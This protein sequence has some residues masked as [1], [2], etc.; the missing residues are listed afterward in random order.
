MKE[1]SL[2]MIVK[3]EE[4]II[5]RCLDS[6][7][8]LVDEIII[9]DTGSTDRTKEIVSKYTD[10]VFDF[11]WVDDFAKARNFSFSKA[12]KDYILWLDADDIILEEDRKNF[13]KLKNELDGSVDIYQMKYNYTVDENNNPTFV[14]VRVRLVKREKNYQWVSPIHEV[15]IPSGNIKKVDISITHKKEEIKD[16]ERNLKIFQKLEKEG[17]I[18]D[19]RQEYCYA[20]EFYCLR[21]YEEAVSKYEKYI[22]KYEN[23]YKTKRIFLYPAILELSDC[24]K[25]LEKYDKRLE[26]LLKVLKYEIPGSSACCKIGECFMDRK[27]YDTARFWFESAIRNKK[28]VKED[29]DANVDYNEYVP[30]IDLCVCYYW[31]GDLEK[32][33]ECN[34]KA[35]RIKPDSETYLYNKKILK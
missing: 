4:D 1:I 21:R 15:I 34:E 25:I 23:D 9:V 18:L 33:R 31:L 3:N 19:D 32:A 27:E 2:C 16:S 26:I 30:Y 20:K 14:Q 28:D 10:K 22:E 5:G 12:T 35:G 6:I 13:L 17:K 7:K 29:G 24:Y 8:D 11:K